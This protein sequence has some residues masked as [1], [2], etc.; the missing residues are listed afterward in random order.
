MVNLYNSAY[1][2]EMPDRMQKRRKD[3]RLMKK[4]L[5]TSLTILLILGGTTVIFAA[6]NTNSTA[7]A[8]DATTDAAIESDATSA[9]IE[10]VAAN[11]AIE[12]TE[13][14]VTI[15]SDMT[16][17][18]TPV[19]L[20]LDDAYKKMLADSPGAKMADLNKQNADGVSRGYGESVQNIKNAKKQEKE[21]GDVN[22]FLDTT[23]KEM[24]E[25]NKK[26]A[27]AQGP[28]NYDAEMN[29]LKRDTI[30]NYY[31][32]KELENQVKIAKDNL[33][34]KEKLL[35]NTQLKHKLGTVAK[36][37]VLE[38]E[39]SVNKAKDQAIA[40][41]NG[42]NTMKM[43]FNQ[44]M[45]YD[46][47]Q[48][49]TLADS[50]KEISLSNKTLTASIKDA[51]ANRNE[52]HEAAYSLQMT[53][54]LLD[55]LKAY[56]RG[57]STYIKAKMDALMAE[58]NS[59]NA[60]LTVENDVRTKYMNMNEKHSAVQ[61]GKKAVENAKEMERLAQLQYDV[62]MATLSDVEGAQL[63]YY[64]AQLDYS[65][66]L[67]EYNLAVYDY[68]QASTVGTTSAVIK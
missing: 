65:K 14:A 18:G 48:N 58:T 26:Y 32:L 41:Q 66:A 12:T 40:A 6:D 54:M 64:N 51:L 3:L 8:L 68:E 16:F 36:A 50:I 67:L 34:L 25:A 33:A 21:S 23:N 37:D 55:T 1:G 20:S 38:A 47:M 35:S 22:W 15:V 39:I 4:F 57:S 19:K 7:A 2:T 49:V 29:D 52:I 43:G 44:F 42:L 30:N 62:G 46:L 9:A 27:A 59:K 5:C 56:P 63:L 31:Q 61:T 13:S 60:P 45:G 17:T 53:H 24:L 11:P 28:R 10:S